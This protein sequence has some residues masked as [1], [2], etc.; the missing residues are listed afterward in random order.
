MVSSATRK[1]RRCA[2]LSNNAA[3]PEK[4]KVAVKAVALVGKVKVAKAQ[5]AGRAKALWE[6]KVRDANSWVAKVE[7]SVD[8]A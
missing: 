1:R 2:N 5:W 8:A 6:A 3:K 4:L 7:A